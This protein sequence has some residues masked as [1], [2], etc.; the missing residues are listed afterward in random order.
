ME[1]LSIDLYIK[2][3]FVFVGVEQT[4]RASAFINEYRRC[5]FREFEVREFKHA[6]IL[7]GR[8]SKSVGMSDEVTVTARETNKKSRH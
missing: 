5:R 6:Q 2:G 7:L 3:P 1:Q 4:R 8:I